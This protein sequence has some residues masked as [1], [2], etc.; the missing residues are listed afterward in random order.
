MNRALRIARVL[1]VAS[2]LFGCAHWHELNSNHE[3]G[4]PETAHPRLVPF[5]PDAYRPYAG[6]GPSTLF[7]Q[8]F[9]KT[10]E[11]DVKIGAGNRVVMDPVTP[12]STEWWNR[13]VL[14]GE[15]LDSSD[16][17]ADAFHRE[18]LADADG[19][20]RFD[21]LPAGDY[22]IACWI[23]WEAQDA[24]GNLS[25]QL[26]CVGKKAH[27]DSPDPIEIIL[28]PVSEYGPVPSGGCR[29]S[30]MGWMPVKATE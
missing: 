10:H 21:K 16:V 25:K 30:T 27:V 1:A 5:D 18:T 19:R 23:S 17:R 9:T 8:A 11:G 28:E 20:F 15:P 3:T 12:Y 22:Y 13:T 7:G 24:D 6:D 26:V 2:L 14:H 29:P 4:S